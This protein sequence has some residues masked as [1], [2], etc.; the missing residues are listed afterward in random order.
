MQLGEP[1]STGR[2]KPVP[3]PGSEYELPADSVIAAVSQQ[4]GWEELTELDPG[5]VWMQPE[6]HGQVN[7][8]IWAGGDALGLGIA[9]MAIA[10]GRQAAEAVHAKLRG[11]EQSN[12]AVRPVIPS[13]VIKP[14]YYP[15]RQPVATRQSP[16]EE[17]MAEPDT[18]IYKTISNT[19]FLQEVYRCFSCGLCNGCE[20]C[21]MYCNAGGFTRLEQ[22]GP[23][24]YFAFSRDDCMRCG[25]CIDL[26]PTGF[27]TPD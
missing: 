14:D 17:R 25:K 27:L 26:C 19:E 18:E 3:V 24:A 2:R 8:N 15:D 22:V 11:L 20:N 4:P 5:T 21:Y 6:A 7:D 23:G 13:R 12:S 1:D 16:I 10:Q 9:G